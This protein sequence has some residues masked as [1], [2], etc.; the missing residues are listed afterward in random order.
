MKRIAIL[1]SGTGSNAEN[2]ARQFEGD[3]HIA[4]EILL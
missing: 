3:K 4:V 2:I 1:A